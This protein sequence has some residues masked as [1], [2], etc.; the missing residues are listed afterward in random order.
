LESKSVKR[1]WLQKFITP[2][3]SNLAPP[4]GVYNRER[5]LTWNLV[6]TS[7]MKVLGGLSDSIFEIRNGVLFAFL[8]HA[9][10]FP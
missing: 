7:G 5:L 3:D 4:N 8:P 2:I 1:N 10:F 6:M 9:L